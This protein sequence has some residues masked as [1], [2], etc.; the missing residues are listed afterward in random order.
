MQAMP[1]CP[2]E[3]TIETYKMLDRKSL[4]KLVRMNWR[5]VVLEIV[6][7]SG[8]P[9]T[10]GSIARIS[11]LSSRTISRILKELTAEKLLE[12]KPMPG[13]GAREGYSATIIGTRIS[14]MPCPILKFASDKMEEKAR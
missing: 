12:R 4:M 10:Y 14:T 5:M 1:W 7:S 6:A 11:G 2:V 13:H 8:E 9:M 3:R